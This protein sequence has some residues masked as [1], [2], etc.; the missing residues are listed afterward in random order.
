MHLQYINLALLID[1]AGGDPWQVNN[2]L[3]SGN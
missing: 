3:Q 1:A 2:T